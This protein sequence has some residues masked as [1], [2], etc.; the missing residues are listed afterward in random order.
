MA[1]LG[2]AQRTVSVLLEHPAVVVVAAV[3]AVS[4]KGAVAVIR[5]AVDASV[6]GPAVDAW[7]PSL[8]SMT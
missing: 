8:P 2:K 4:G 3:A 6:A 7:Q 5:V 1:A